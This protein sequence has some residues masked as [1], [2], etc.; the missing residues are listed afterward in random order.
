MFA[1]VS[2]DV[3]DVLDL[4]EF[5]GQGRQAGEEEFPADDR[6]VTT[7][8]AVVQIDEAIVAQLVDMGFPLEGCKKVGWLIQLTI[9]PIG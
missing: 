4:T 3:P 7:T 9:A 1:D 2:L 6:S 5:R 8:P